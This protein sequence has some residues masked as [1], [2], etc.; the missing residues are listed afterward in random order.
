MRSGWVAAAGVSALALSI[1]VGGSG[2]GALAPL[3]VPPGSG[4][5]VGP[6]GDAVPIAPGV[7]VRPGESGAYT[8]VAASTPVSVGDGVRTDATGFAEVAYSDGS[9]TRLDVNTDFEVVSLT[10]DA[11]SPATRTKMG[12]G[13]TWTRVE[14]VVPTGGGF[15]VETAQATATGREHSVPGVVPDV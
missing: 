13:R 14:S 10:D 2:V 15:V 1:A 9:R 7:E 4:G 8:N 3:S 11:G 6:V 12:L 5:P